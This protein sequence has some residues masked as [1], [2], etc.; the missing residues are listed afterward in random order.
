MKLLWEVK[1]DLDVVRCGALAD[2]PGGFFGWSRGL[3]DGS[4]CNG[5]LAARRDEGTK[6]IVLVAIGGVLK[7]TR[8]SD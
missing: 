8:L 2:G 4:F 7:D 1:A 6:G 5:G 3:G